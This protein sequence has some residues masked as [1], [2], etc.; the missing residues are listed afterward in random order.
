MA[1]GARMHHLLRRLA[2]AVSL[3]AVALL[4]VGSAATAADGAVS[5]DSNAFAPSSVTINRGDSVTWTNNEQVPHDATGSGWFTPMLTLGQSATVTFNS[6][7]TFNYLCTIH[8]EMTGRVVVRAPSGGSG[9][10]F[11][12]PP[13]DTVPLPL[14]VQGDPSS[15]GSL[16]VVIAASLLAFG[17][18][19][20]W[21]AGRR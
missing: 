10:G 11:T 16:V 5:M 1:Y 14:G 7:G 17:F 18:V 19:A 20:R 13:T 12:D 4:A 3:S 2:V 15:G 6:A 8:P 9:P 21:S